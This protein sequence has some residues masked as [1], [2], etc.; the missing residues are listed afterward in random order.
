MRAVYDANVAAT[1]VLLTM[2]GGKVVF[3]DPGL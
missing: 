1:S 2:V 3:A